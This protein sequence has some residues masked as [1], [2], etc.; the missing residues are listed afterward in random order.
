[1]TLLSSK[2]YLYPV[3]NLVRKVVGTY[4]A[5]LEK[6]LKVRVVQTSLPVAPSKGRLTRH[7]FVSLVP[8]CGGQRHALYPSCI[9]ESPGKL[10]KNADALAIWG[11]SVLVKRC[12]W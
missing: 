4:C 10:S 1:M 2:V 11:V 7:V 8:T 3:E 5:S 6:E 12:L 9:L